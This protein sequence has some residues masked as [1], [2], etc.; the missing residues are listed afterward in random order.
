ML[1]P[2]ITTPGAIPTQHLTLFSQRGCLGFMV[3]WGCLGLPGVALHASSSRGI[4]ASTN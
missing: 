4:S 2:G 3:A 1:W